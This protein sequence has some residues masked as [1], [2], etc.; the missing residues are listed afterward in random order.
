MSQRNTLGGSGA[1]RRRHGYRGYG[2]P[3]RQNHSGIVHWGRG[4]GGAGFAGET[5]ASTL[6]HAEILS[7]NQRSANT[8]NDLES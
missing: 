6:P 3:L 2:S 8:R 7:E 4:F 5:V 1:K